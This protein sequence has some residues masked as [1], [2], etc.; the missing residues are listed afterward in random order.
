MNKIKVLLDR[1]TSQTWAVRLVQQGDSYGL[2]D[3]LVHDRPAPLVEFYDTRHPH[4]P[5]GQFVAAYSL[6]TLLAHGAQGL[7]LD[8]GVPEWRVST[9]AMHELMAW[10]NAVAEK[11]PVPTSAELIGTMQRMVLARAR[12]HG[13]AQMKS[14]YAD[15]YWD[16]TVYPDGAVSNR[17][18]AEESRG[19]S[20]QL[21]DLRPWE[22][23]GLIFS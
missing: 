17:G 14:H 5:L 10:L 16:V 11:P 4:T 1:E 12:E 7:N 22:L 13:D 23:V 15:G 19:P 20:S 18:Y 6:P 8:G 3:Q 9:A 2:K 21:G